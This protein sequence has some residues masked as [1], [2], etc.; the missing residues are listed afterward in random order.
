MDTI[1]VCNHS[2]GASHN[3]T[4]NR[5]ARWYASVRV[6]SAELVGEASD[7]TGVDIERIGPT[8]YLKCA[9]GDCAETG[10]IL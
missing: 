9:V 5:V 10:G 8:D 1:Q 3:S 7:R 2:P 6:E 4:W